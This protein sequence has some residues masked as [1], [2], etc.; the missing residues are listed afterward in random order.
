MLVSSLMEKGKIEFVQIESQ[1]GGE[2]RLRNPWPDTKVALERSGDK[3]EELSGDLL[4]FST[5]KGELITIRP[6]R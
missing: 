5:T 3:A 1:A 6:S 2:C 4:R